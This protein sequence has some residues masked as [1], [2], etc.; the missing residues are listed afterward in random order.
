MK[1]HFCPDCDHKMTYTIMP[2]VHGDGGE[3]IVAGERRLFICPY[4]G[5]RELPPASLTNGRTERVQRLRYGISKLAV[6][7]YENDY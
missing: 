4:C 5:N 3:E 2:V 6:Y 1:I 7:E